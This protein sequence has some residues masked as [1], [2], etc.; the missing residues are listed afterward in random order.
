MV[1]T[2]TV[3]NTILML[4][5]YEKKLITPMKLQKLMYFVYKE[6]LQTT[7]CQLFSESFEKWQYGPV[8]PSIYY[9]FRNFGSDF[10]NK[11]ARDAKGNI[12]IINME[13]DT[14]I[15]EIIKNVWDKYKNYRA[16]QLSALTHRDESAWSKAKDYILKD[17]DIKNEPDFL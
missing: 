13:N 14:K 11:F 3:A 12:E 4:S 7:N 9:E 6:Y 10:I 2:Q 16:Y 8:L 1:N 15:A 17:E 5:F